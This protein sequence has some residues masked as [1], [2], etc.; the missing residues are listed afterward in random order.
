MANAIGS[1]YLGKILNSPPEQK[2]NLHS[3]QA[4]KI[5]IRINILPPEKAELEEHSTESL[6]NLILRQKQKQSLSNLLFYHPALAT[7]KLALRQPG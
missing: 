6:V 2:T 5:L 4:Q 3:Q 7:A 1:L